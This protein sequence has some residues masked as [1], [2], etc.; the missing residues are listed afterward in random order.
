M[1]VEVDE[2]EGIP[3]C[4][5]DGLFGRKLGG[6]GAFGE[7]LRF[8]VEFV[9]GDKEGELEMGSTDGDFEGL[10]VACI[11][12]GDVVGCLLFGGSVGV[13]VGSAEG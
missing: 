5:S 11:K 12:F 1:A 8:L 13:A 2:A 7:E 3:D 4:M 10:P 6:I 9:G